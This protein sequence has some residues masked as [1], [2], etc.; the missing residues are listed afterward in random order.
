MT[1]AGNHDIRGTGALQAYH[2]F[3]PVRISRELGKDITKTTFSFRVGPDVYIALD[4]EHPDDKEL[5]K[6]LDESEDARYTFILC[7]SS[8]F[9]SDDYAARWFFHG[10][11]KPEHT[12]AR[13]HICSALS[14]CK[15]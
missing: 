12:A 2:E 10:R 7:H 6:L 13:R 15:P 3:M 4:F 11:N 14:P 1:V 9:P 8:L 5:D